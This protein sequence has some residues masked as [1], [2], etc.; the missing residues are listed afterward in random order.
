MGD[1][2]DTSKPNEEVQKRK[3][4]VLRNLQEALGTDKL[5][6]Q[7]GTEGKVVHVYWGTATT[8]R[9]HVGYFV[10]MRKIADFLKAGLKVTVL[11]ADLHAFLDNMKSTWELLENRV[12]YYEHIIKALLTA[13]DVPIERLHFVRGTAYQLSREYT[14]DMI[15]LCGQVSHRDAL[16][17]GAE[18]VKQVESP[19]LSGL[20][21]PLLQALDEQYLKVDGQFGGVD[22]RKIFILAEEQLPKL[23]L[24]KR[25]HLMNPMVPGLTGS[26]MS[27]SEIDSKIDLLD[28]ADVVERKILGAVCPRQ[29]DD[30]G[31]LAFYNY[32]L[33]PIVSPNSLSIAN[34]EFFTYEEIKESFLSGQLSAEDLK[35]ALVQ[36]HCRSDVVR[37]ALEKGYAEV[38]G[39]VHDSA[40]PKEIPLTPEQGEKLLRIIG[41]EKTVGSYSTL[42]SCIAENRPVRVS[43]IIHP[44]GR[45]HLGFVMGLLKMKEMLA[46]GLAINGIVLISDMEAFCDNEKVSWNAREARTD[47]F[48]KVCSFFVEQLGLKE[49]VKVLKSADL[50]SVFS[51]D[52]VLNFYKMASAVT[53]EET[54][55]CEGTS[56][57]CNLVPLF[58]ALNHG[59]LKTDLA[60]MGED[61]APIAELA[62]K[63]WSQLKMQPPTQ[64]LFATLPGCDGKKMSCSSPDFILD[65]F[66]TQKQM[67][68]KVARS[69]CEPKNLEGNVAMMLA[70]QFVFPLLN[71]EALAIERSAENG[72]NVSSTTYEE[73]EHEFVT[74]SNPEFPLHPGDLKNAVVKFLNSFF[75]P[76]RTHFASSQ[77]ALLAAAF[78]TTKKGKK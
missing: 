40:P 66:D 31:V 32:V 49:S 67:K 44:K 53:R 71:G 23:K 76:A 22:Q 51:H 19:L 42:R 4:L 3:D 62:V 60:I 52:Y 56:L 70:K 48:H 57:S 41:D 74:G 35:K 50:D 12:I 59:L 28:S 63:L 47:Y 54:T 69:F 64:L 26:K 13:L 73:L 24:G 9:P 39:V 20:L 29:E 61:S 46:A 37:D 14:F 72:G 43:F 78:P 68:V 77:N 75:E 36:S 11:F 2:S 30:N 6:K 1:T 55:I 15:R 65:P 18:V 17:A 27:S 38:D 16:R 10:P 33:I 34:R 45:F 7:L 58:Y 8:G 25:W 5:E 21:Y